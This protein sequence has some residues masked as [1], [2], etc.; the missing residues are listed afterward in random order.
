VNRLVPINLAV[1]DILSEAAVKKILIEA[2]QD[3]AIGTTY[4]KRGFGYL[5]KAIF[6]FCKA[7][8][9]TPFLVLTDLD[10][11]D[12][13]PTLVQ[14]WLPNGVEA[15]LIFRVAVREVEAWL[16]ADRTRLADFLGVRESSIPCN[17]DDLADPKAVI[18]STAALSRRRAIRAALVPAPRT[19]AKVGPG[20]ND[21]LVEFVRDYWVPCEAGLR[22][23][24][25]QRALDRIHAFAPSWH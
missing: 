7:A 23:P 1:E 12:C 18:V 10:A 25:L 6:G 5:K 3:F 14:S 17:P 13:A 19:T 9:T 4:G 11:T 8:H 20:Y 22:S 21:T 2:P 15:N 16:I 24:S